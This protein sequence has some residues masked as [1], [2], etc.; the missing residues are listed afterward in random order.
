M[1][2]SWY[3]MA[4]M[5]LFAAFINVPRNMVVPYLVIFC[6]LALWLV[7]EETRRRPAQKHVDGGLLDHV[8]I[9]KGCSI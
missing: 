5:A 7:E 4:I 9:A 3:V 8:R 2:T 6:A 1:R